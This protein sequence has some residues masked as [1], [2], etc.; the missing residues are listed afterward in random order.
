MS[1][2]NPRYSPEFLA[3]IDRTIT[4]ERLK[5]YLAAA[6]QDLT[7][8][9]ELYEY[10]I[11]LSEMMYGLLHG[12]EVGVRNALHHTLTDAYQTQEWYDHAPLSVYHQDKFIRKAKQEA[13][14]NASPGKVIAELTFGFWTDLT[15]HNYHWTLWVPNNLARAFPNAAVPRKHIHRRLE[16]IRW[17]RNRIAHHEPILTSQ[18]R[19]YAGHQRFISLPELEECGHWVCSHMAGWLK[20]EFRYTPAAEILSKVNAMGVNL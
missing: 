13:G 16:T 12:L 6:G 5:R 20:R 17:L 18:N 15:A 9:L 11:A 8:A 19:V 7:R 14:P 3:S 4:R 1:T 2:S 10:N